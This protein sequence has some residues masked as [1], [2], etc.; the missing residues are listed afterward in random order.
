LQGTAIT[1]VIGQHTLEQLNALW[2]WTNPMR[3]FVGI[4]EIFNKH[5]V[6]GF[7]KK[8]I[9]GKWKLLE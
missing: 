2:G 3:I 4:Y 1:L 9:C 5:W 8:S 6:S 7:L